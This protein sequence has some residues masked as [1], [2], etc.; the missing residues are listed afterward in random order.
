MPP[1]RIAMWSGPRNISTAMMRA[2]GSRADTFVVDEPFYARYLKLTG[3][4]HPARDEVIAHHET[5]LDRIVASLTGPLP[6][7]AAGKAV[8]YQKH[9]AHH[10]L[11]GDGL[12][13]TRHVVNCFLIRDPAEAIA[14]FVKIVPNPSAQQLGLPQQAMLFDLVRRRAGEVP[15][16]ID[17]RDVLENPRAVLSALCRRL[18]LDF[19]DAMLRWEPGP[20][21]T[22][23]VWAPHW[24]SAVYR[25]TGFEPH[26]PRTEPV[27]PELEPVHA[28]CRRLYDQLHRHCLDG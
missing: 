25:S 26:R 18:N 6:A 10:V 2:W 3:A 7:G 14:S 5:D 8:Y 22:D 16:V 20:R 11:P 21:P 12:D 28:E 19:D 17:A 27:P 1:L 15:P 4:D 13:W 24:Y 23:G 9:M